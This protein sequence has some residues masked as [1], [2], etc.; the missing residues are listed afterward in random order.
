MLAYSLVLIGTVSLVLVLYL[1]GGPEWMLPS[2][3]VRVERFRDIDLMLV[4]G[5]LLLGVFMLVGFV[6]IMRLQSW[7]W[8]MS[9]IVQGV[10][11]AILLAEY[12]RGLPSFWQMFVGTALVFL[13][14]QR[15]VQ[16]AFTVA[17]HRAEPTSIR[18]AQEDQAAARETQATLSRRP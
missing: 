17:Q 13:L 3:V 6:G 8:L 1:S 14:N 18:T 4:A 12:V 7:A 9:M 15:E 5:Q 10:N 11:L 16:R 2:I